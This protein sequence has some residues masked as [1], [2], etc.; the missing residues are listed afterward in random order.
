M[1]PHLAILYA[2]LIIL[3]LSIISQTEHTDIIIQTTT[4]TTQTATTEMPQEVKIPKPNQTIP[5]RV[6]IDESSGK[7]LLYFD[8]YTITDTKTALKIWE[9][10]TKIINFVEVENE[11]V[12]DMIIKWSSNLTKT[13]GKKTVG[14]AWYREQEIGGTIYLLPSGMSCRNQGRTMHEIGHLFGLNHST[15]YLS[16]MYNIESCAQNI[17]D[18]DVSNVLKIFGE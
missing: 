15:N 8:N 13:P 18:E 9:E 4:S 5:L 3:L 6:F 11:K 10:R 7:G 12:A 1:K 17:T 14:E 2:L 16:V